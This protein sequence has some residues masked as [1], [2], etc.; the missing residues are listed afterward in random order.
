MN[1]GARIVRA[2]IALALAG[3]LAGCGIFGSGGNARG[4]TY[5]E[6]PQNS[7]AAPVAPSPAPK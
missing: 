6:I 3:S 2:I 4:K 5:I 1:H 7:A